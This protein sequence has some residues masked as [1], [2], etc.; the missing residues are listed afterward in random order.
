MKDLDR[1]Q[2]GQDLKARD[3][4]KKNSTKRLQVIPAILLSID[5]FDYAEILL[6]EHVS[7][8]GCNTLTHLP[9]S[10][11]S[12]YTQ[13]ETCGC[14]RLYLQE[15]G[16]NIG[17]KG[18]FSPPFSSL[19]SSY[20]LS[21]SFLPSRLLL[22]FPSSSGCNMLLRALWEEIG[23]PVLLVCVLTAPSCSTQLAGHRQSRECS[24]NCV[25]H[26]GYAASLSLSTL[27]ASASCSLMRFTLHSPLIY[28]IIMHDITVYIAMTNKYPTLM[29]ESGNLK[30]I[31]AVEVYF[32]V[33]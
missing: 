5:T 24:T 23:P 28:C 7:A 25:G 26:R 10:A 9:E 18:F 2:E 33:R 21:L 6:P 13:S 4:N 22:C 32:L 8:L 15:F 29:F 14:V 17:S 30:C 11:E 12:E 1:K 27:F 31:T 20:S 3:L 19:L 16:L